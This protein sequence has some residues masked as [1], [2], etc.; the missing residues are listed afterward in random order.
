[1][2]G[3]YIDTRTGEY[4][5][6]PHTRRYKPRQRLYDLIVALAAYS[7]TVTTL[8]VYIVTR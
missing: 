6:R 5:T 4:V 7:L 1:M 2:I 3:R 8:L